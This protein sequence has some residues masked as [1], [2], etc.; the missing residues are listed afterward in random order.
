VIHGVVVLAA[1][2]EVEGDR[3]RDHVVGARPDVGPDP[4]LG[5]RVDILVRVALEYIR[6]SLSVRWLISAKPAAFEKRAWP[7]S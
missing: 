1:D 7:W 4:V 5:P 6:C 3:V 2:V